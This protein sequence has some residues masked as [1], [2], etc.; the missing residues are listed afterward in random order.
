M[1]ELHDMALD[2]R[3]RRINPQRL[4]DLLRQGADDLV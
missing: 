2:G 1:Q 3:L 4:R